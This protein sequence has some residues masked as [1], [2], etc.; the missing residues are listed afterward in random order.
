M[1]YSTIYSKL[2][3][4]Q[5]KAV[6]RIEGCVMVV[7]GPGTGKTQV[8]GARVA[9]ILQKTDAQPEN[10]VCLTFT[11]AATIALRQ[12]LNQFIG[13]DS[14]K[15]NIYTYHGF[16]NTVIQ[17]NKDLFGIQD[18][19]PIS[20]LETIEVLREIIDELSNDSLLKRFTGDVYY[21][22]NN[23]KKLFGLLK[24]D[25]LDAQKI[26][27][28][29]EQAKTEA[30]DDPSM[31]YARKYGKFQKGDLKQHKIDLLHESLAKLKEATELLDKYTQKLKQRKRY[32][33][34][35]MLTWVLNALQQHEDLL[36]RYQEQYHYFLVDEYQDTNGIQNELL[37]TL[38]NYWDNPNVFV[39]GDDD[40][41]IYKF[42]GANVENIYD[43]YKAY[44][45]HVKLLVLD[46]NYRSSQEILDG[47]NAIIKHNKE[48]LVGKVPGLNKEIKAA[49]E[50][51]AHISGA[52]NIIEYPNTYQ[53]V[54]S[55]T[56]KL[57]QF[58]ADGIPL[59]EVG[60]LYRN[61]AQSEDL[62]KFLEA[63]GISYN[64]AKSQNVLEIPI[65]HQLN[66]FLT[67]LSLE[68]ERL[69]SG[70]HLLFEILH[71]H[72][73]K[74]ISALDIARISHKLSKNR[75]SG[76]RALLN[77]TAVDLGIGAQSKAEMRGFVA[78]IEYWLKEMHNV[79]LQN[80]VERVMSKIGFV[81][82]ALASGD[83]TFQIQCL[84]TYYNFLK[85]ETAREPYLSLTEFLKKIELL[86]LNK[87]GLKLN[88]VVHGLNGVNLMTV[89]GSKGL[90]F[91]Y[92]F[93]MGCTEDKWEKDRK[94]LPFKLNLLLPG[95]PA[96]AAEEESRRLFYVAL[97]RARKHIE[98]S[99][100]R[101]ND[102]EKDLI[103]SLFVVELE[104]SGAA[105]TQQQE[106]TEEDILHFFDF[107]MTQKNKEFVSLVKQDFV[108]KEVENF[109]LSATNLNSY[110]RCPVA[111]FYQNIIRVPSARNESTVFGTAV[112]F[113]LD[114]FFKNREMLK[115]DKEAIALLESK[116]LYFMNTSKE[117]FTQEGLKRR[118][119]YGTEILTKYYH[120]YKESW[121]H[122]AEIK[123]EVYLKNCE[124]DGVPI[125]GQLDKVVITGDSAHVIDFKTGN[126]EYGKKKLKPP[127]SLSDNPDEAN[128]EKRHGGDYWR[129]V[130]FYKA[131]VESDNTT[132]LK[133]ISGE[134]DFVEPVGDDFHKI[135]IMVSEE[136]YSVVRN[137]IKDTFTRI[138]N[139][140]FD[141]GC[142]EDDCQWCTF[143]AT[144][145][146]K[147]ISRAEDLLATDE[148]QET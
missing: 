121:S 114:A 18:V 9:S 81:G 130:L 94:T 42:Q 33:F 102:K 5:Q 122:E 82:R 83:A 67:Y 17:E 132:S 74:H 64:V 95:E 88:K 100:A 63:E 28:K 118:S 71:Y 104:E 134:I 116:F 6:D 57:K 112:H 36:L 47:S 140:E 29:I 45:K 59:N 93:V 125:R 90:E 98:I 50:E 13:S 144:Y 31:Y 16:C 78:D 106:A 25:N 10:I 49:N 34:N 103:K 65:V 143:N 12:R 22:V 110:L 77:D 79:T 54:V 38:I 141:K 142:E 4:N 35:D 138:Q 1:D 135:K 124:I 8:L 69:E 62:I 123:T 105:T 137:Q 117:S 91:D 52:L 107:M 2:N 145:K 72:N 14:Y 139:L 60:I 24:K 108:K 48:R 92:L 119:F 23:L 44:E 133:V 89:H 7:A 20:E 127:I 136:E 27:S 147:Q 129:Q 148:Y 37:Y 87:I 120:H 76:W 128:F 15:V 43:F 61:H 32:D 84:K 3:I 146:K 26:N 21:D 115:T 55:I 39:V 51:V 75:D 70:E 46:Q 80:L 126:Y 99:Y 19:D 11:E 41:S 53:E 86:Q 56:R 109:R 97:T 66:N 101:Q 96:S 131:L 30:L 111:F 73:F 113:A 85:E 58:R 68:S 40:Q